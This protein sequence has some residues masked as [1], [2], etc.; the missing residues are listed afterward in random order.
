MKGRIDLA[1]RENCQEENLK[2]PSI[3]RDDWFVLKRLSELFTAMYDIEQGE[4]VG[5]KPKSFAWWHEKGH[6]L[7][8]QNRKI[9]K[10][11]RIM[12]WLE[13]SVF[14]LLFASLIFL[15]SGSFD[16]FVAFAFLATIL[17]VPV[18]I[19]IMYLEID[20]HVYALKNIKR[21]KWK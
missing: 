19:Q 10:A 17:S 15:L 13:L 9:I 21:W 4:I 6:E 1:K 20:A 11:K 12:S 5:C 2:T 8:F 7:Q 14:S 18:F 16:G 3:G